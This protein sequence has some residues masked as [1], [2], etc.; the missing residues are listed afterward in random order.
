MARTYQL[1][2][3]TAV[4]QSF[5]I[6]YRSLLNE[7]QYEAVTCFN[8]PVLC[9]A[10][11][12]S[13]KTRTL[14]YRVARMLESGIAPDSILLLTFTRKAAAN[15]LDR[16]TTLVG[17]TGKAVAGGTY[18]SFAANI[19]RRYG[20]HIELNPGFSII[21]E[22]DASDI[23]NLLR[24]EMGFNRK[25]SRFPQKKTVAQ[26]FSKANNL[27]KSL[28]DVISDLYPQFSEHSQDICRLYAGFGEYK[29]KNLLLDYDDLLIY[30]HRLL[31]DSETARAQITSRYRYVM[32]DEYQ[33]TNGLQAR[34]T[35]LLAGEK[36][37]VMV[38]GDDA[39]SIYSFR[40]ARVSN[41]LEFPEAFAD[42]RVIRLER[43][44]RST[45]H[46]LD[47]ANSLMEKAGEG[48]KKKLYTE[49]DSGELP[50]CVRCEDEQ[51]QAMFV[52]ARVL[53]LRE[54]GIQLN[55]MA[56]LFRSSFHAYQLELELK[57][58]NIPYV[59]WG[60]FK[61][62]EAG[63]LKD[64]I[65]HLRIIQN[66][67]DQVSWLR[68]LLLIEGVGTHSAGEIFSHIRQAE[69]PFDFSGIK[70]RPKAGKGLG[71]LGQMLLSA[72]ALVNSSPARLLEIVADYYFPILK[73]RFDDYPR[74]FKDIDQL[75]II[76][77]RFS[78]LSDF[79]SD[80]ALEPPRDSVDEALAPDQSED[81]TLILSTIHSAKGLEWHSVFVIYALEGRFPSFSSLKSEA[82][83][84]EERRLM[85]VAITRAE[86]NLAITCPTNIW[87]PVSGTVLGRQSRF[88]D[89]ITP[90]LLENWQISRS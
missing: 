9:I 63:H 53:E 18:H 56:V 16:V 70:A 1:N 66:P 73:E 28:A 36:R 20:H 47:A 51:E 39:Q 50:A 55:K 19:L 69:N 71:K 88:L 49:K 37:N 33:D 85:Y 87:D 59:K 78:S 80:L 89:E 15:M 21:D 2:T 42:C 22:G 74:R 54:Q 68:A 64:I 58:R 40:G 6:D 14:I 90:D 5:K 43:N 60:G 76:A 25:E 24:S 67:F 4:G 23:I 34:I 17:A 84:E 26:M 52:A 77:G 72:A 7:Q 10:G 8:G 83:L 3:E 82:D 12:G 79:L 65:A 11:A 29:Q 45:R 57:R 62:L 31:S 32:A 35:I 27:E 46:I 61:F 41:I 48:F 75:A 30:M 13:G 38:V 86:E 81:E 44:Y